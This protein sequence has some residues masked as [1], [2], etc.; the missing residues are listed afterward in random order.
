MKIAIG[1]DHIVTPQKNQ[2]VDYLH[3]LK[4]FVIDF[5]TNDQIRTHYPLYGHAVGVAVAKKEVDL[6]IVICGTGVGI[7]NAA[8][9][10]KGVRCIL[11]QRPIVA[12]IAKEQYDANVLAMG[13]EIVGIGLMKKIIQFF[14]NSNYLNK[15]KSAIKFCNNLIKHKNYDPKLL[16]KE[17]NDW[18]CG[19]Y[20]QNL[21]PKKINLP[22]PKIIKDK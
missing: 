2:I 14:L 22:D 6:G 5:G 7:G 11:T 21:I 15:N 1:C 3:S 10:V 20:T 16:E 13:G 8:N 9:K 19:C 12:K 18:N 4:H 17:V